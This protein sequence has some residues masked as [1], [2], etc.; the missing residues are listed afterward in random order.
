[1]DLNDVQRRV[2][3]HGEG[4]LVVT[5]VAGAGKTRTLIFRIA[6]LV[7][8]RNVEPRQILATTFTVKAAT[9]M[10][11]RLRGIRIPVADWRTPGVTVGTV[12]SVALQI[13]KSEKADMDQY[14]VD[15][16]GR[17]YK[18][19][20]RAVR[21]GSKSVELRTL[22]TWIGRMKAMR[23]DPTEAKLRAKGPEK[24][25]A[26][27]YAQA[28]EER[29]SRHILT[30]DDMMLQCAKLLED[31]E[32]R[33]RQAKWE[34]VLQDEVQDENLVQRQ[35]LRALAHRGNY[36]V[37][38]DPMQ[39]IYSFRGSCATAMEDFVRDFPDAS[40]ISM[41][42]NYR[43]GTRILDVA[44]RVSAGVVH[45]EPADANNQ[46]VVL[47]QGYPTARL[48]A[49]GVV[50][51]VARLL[52]S[53]AFRPA[54]ICILCR[55]HNQ[56]AFFEEELSHRQI[57]YLSAATGS[58]YRRREVAAMLSYLRLL[59]GEGTSDDLVTTFFTPSRMVKKTVITDVAAG[60]DRRKPLHKGL[61]DAA[62]AR[63]LGGFVLRQI[64]AW[65]D[66]YAQI[67]AK[68][69]GTPGSAMDAIEA[70]IQLTRT[71][72]LESDHMDV[73]DVMRDL[74]ERAEGFE[75]ISAFLREC[76]RRQQMIEEQ[77]RRN[78]DAVV[79]STV[80]A[81]KGLEW[82]C[83]FVAGISHDLF[84]HVFSAA[85]PEDMAEERRLLYVAVTRARDVLVCSYAKKPSEYWNLL[86][87][88]P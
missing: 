9:E 15:G 70:A 82:P 62:L 1:M 81:A 20:L 42:T 23:I 58:L 33:A 10:A 60:I 28:E 24:A 46:G 76:V 8:L 47:F 67:C 13:L 29:E 34:Y 40:Q 54:Q 63:G 5:A 78:A 25:L 22:E 39:T 59:A 71:V 31:P 72:Q 27:L 55:T 75:T 84:P 57:S 18:D 56:V 79:L 86:Q 26:Q 14:K 6:A 66:D 69:H 48:E 64:R 35:I 32:V 7:L 45:L 73:R 17:L 16:D 44:N 4:P 43:S 12:H 52:Q 3:S 37:V 36:M 11:E 51:Q 21:R 61:L 50:D 41:T 65:C 49:E 68:H 38:G 87:G 19:I 88:E 80:H 83:V 85:S 77:K 30:F 53:G 2:I 74:R